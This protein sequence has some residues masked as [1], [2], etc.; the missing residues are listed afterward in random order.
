M[1]QKAATTFKRIKKI[2]KRFK[3]NKL[4]C[5]KKNEK[6]RKIVQRMLGISNDFSC[7]LEVLVGACW[8]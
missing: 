6:E 7:M 4:F 1:F 3:K 5:L 8:L 2:K